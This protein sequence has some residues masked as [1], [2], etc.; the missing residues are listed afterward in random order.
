MSDLAQQF[1]L[2]ADDFAISEGAS[3]AILNLVDAGRLTA[4]SAM[5]S[6]PT[7]R[8]HA[9]ELKARRGQVAIGLHLDL[10]SRP[11]EGRKPP[12]DLRRLI[13][14][15][16][17]RSVDVNAIADE[18]ER[19]FSAFESAM[20]ARP[21]HVDG[22][23]HAHALPQIRVALLK[24]LARRYGALPPASRPLVRNPADSLFRLWRRGAARRKALMLLGLCAGFGQR[25]NAAGFPA[26]VGFAGFSSLDAGTP[27]ER[28]LAT[29]LRAPGPRHLVMCHPGVDVAAKRGRDPIAARRNVEYASLMRNPRL[30]TAMLR[31]QRSDGDER[32][33]FA[34]WLAN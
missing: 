26:N 7:W 18:F 27:F 24:V 12:Y 16:M 30:L 19:Q 23:H 29:F 32:S 15:S 3:R 11:F 17:T 2:C 10:T 22:H 28:E 13:V 9:A 6:A 8:E 14:S 20:G 21:D 31:V 5:A 33:A 1:V 34:K 4:V 25:V